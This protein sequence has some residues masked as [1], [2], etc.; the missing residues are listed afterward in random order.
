MKKYYQLF[1]FLEKNQKDED[2]GIYYSFIRTLGGVLR[3]SN[4]T[5]PSMACIYTYEQAIYY[6]DYLRLRKIN[7]E[8]K[9]VQNRKDEISIKNKN[10]N[11][12]YYVVYWGENEKIYKSR[13]AAIEHAIYSMP[14]YLYS[15][16][17]SGNQHLEEK[18]VYKSYKKK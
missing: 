4:V 7:C 14:S 5:R 15:V 18:F 16:D 9:E 1:E 8:I 17:Y 11:N 3:L 12:K 2:L 6:Q 13:S 10:Y